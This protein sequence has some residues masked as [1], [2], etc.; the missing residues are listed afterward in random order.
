[1]QFT[2]NVALNS[3]NELRLYAFETENIMRLQMMIIC[4]HKKDTL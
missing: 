3:V 1:M 4:I 2:I